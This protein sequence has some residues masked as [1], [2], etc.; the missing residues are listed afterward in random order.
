MKKNNR[1]IISDLLVLCLKGMLLEQYIFRIK[2][3]KNGTSF[4]EKKKQKK[5]SIKTRTNK[6][7]AEKCQ[8]FNQKD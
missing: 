7:I 6:Y 8:Y 4:K 1:T 3:K 5:K 2:R